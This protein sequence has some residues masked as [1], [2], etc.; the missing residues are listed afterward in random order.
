MTR[1]RRWDGAVVG[2]LGLT[3]VGVVAGTDLLLLLAVAA[4][5][6]VVVGTLS[7]APPA[8]LRVERSLGVDDPR[9]GV[10]VTVT[11]AV[12]NDGDRFVPDVRVVE[13]VPDGVRVV[14][15]TPAF[16]TSL[17]PGGS[18]TH[19]YEVVPSRGEYAFGDPTVT[20]R[21]LPSTVA[22]RTPT[23]VEGVTAFTCETVLDGIPLR[24]QT[25]QFLGE[26]PTDEGGSGVEFYSIREYRPGDP[27][28]RIDW[29]RLARTGSLST[30]EY[31]EERAVTVVFLVDDRAAAHVAAP[32]GGP[33]SFD[34][35]LYAASRGVVASLEE[36]NPTG[37]ATLSGDWV[38]PGAD[39]YT[40]K[41]AEDALSESAPE[42]DAVAT[43]G[44]HFER[45][46]GR[47]PR[48]A[49]LVVCGPV[50]D[51]GIVDVVDALAARGHDVSLLSPDMTT[52]VGGVQRTVGTRLADLRRA[53]RL[54][55]LRALDVAV[56]DW[57][58]AEPI[59]IEIERLR[60]R[61][62]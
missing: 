11:L 57:N 3:L 14:R 17:A 25:I 33:D 56:A 18:A 12:H 2:A 15:G 39:G 55:E 20:R 41:Q 37:V 45:L 8:D 34:L 30:V 21:N 29:N 31:R 54:R 16:A 43:D 35:T 49:Q 6:V 27:M 52:G 22:E 5:G 38:D 50:V 51:D 60:R 1:V 26:T 40:R 7:R 19:E 24:D 36:G 59:M 28:G 4:L 58:L 10:P 44:G 53:N 42:A 23:P 9:P 46:V 48:N 62:A 61:W 32:S 47:L 13:D